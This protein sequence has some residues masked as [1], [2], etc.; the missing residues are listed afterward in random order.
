MKI[1]TN[2]LRPNPF[3]D[4]KRY[5]VDRVKIETLKKSISDTEFWDNLLARKVNGEYQIA[6]G[7]HRL[8]ALQELGIEEIDIPVKDIPDFQMIRIMANENSI[9]YGGE[10]AVILETV[11]AVREF[12][13]AELA[14]YDS[15]EELPD[16]LM[17]LLDSERTQDKKTQFGNLK[18]KGVG[19][20]TLLKFL[21]DGWKQ[22]QIQDALS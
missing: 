11:R 18:S 8:V 13:N 4:L 19:Q 6:Y 15:L 9:Q 17:N 5:P 3:R 1:K 20:A 21:G 14:K 12:L 16:S 2:S 7:H 22:Y 10:P